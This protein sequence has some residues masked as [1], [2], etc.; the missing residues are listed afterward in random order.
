MRLIEIILWKSSRTIHFSWNVIANINIE[1][2]DLYLKGKP[3]DSTLFI[4]IYLRKMGNIRNYQPLYLH[5][6]QKSGN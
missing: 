3:E 2:K 6:V 4:H 5:I 1:N